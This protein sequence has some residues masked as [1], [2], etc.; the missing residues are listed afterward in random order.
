MVKEIADSH[1]GGKWQRNPSWSVSAFVFLFPTSWGFISV[2]ALGS[3]PLGSLSL[4]SSNNS[5]GQPALQHRSRTF[6]VGFS[7]CNQ[8]P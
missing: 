2:N 8:D 5:A 4:Q 3:C 6:R 1:S 7:V